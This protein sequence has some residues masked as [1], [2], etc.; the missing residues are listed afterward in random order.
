M[1]ITATTGAKTAQQTA[2]DAERRINEALHSVINESAA[3]H[4][5][6]TPRIESFAPSPKHITAHA[7]R[8][9]TI[10][11]AGQTLEIMVIASEEDKGEC[12][13]RCCESSS[14]ICPRSLPYSDEVHPTS[15]VRPGDLD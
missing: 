5:G 10:S 8:L 3:R 2:E 9:T 15:G 1:T 12:H 14:F 4:P 6:F 13:P 7:Q 11:A